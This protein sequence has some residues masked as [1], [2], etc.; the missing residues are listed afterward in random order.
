MCVTIHL[1]AKQN[2][3]NPTTNQVANDEVKLTI[4]NINNC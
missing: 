3:S 4:V 1:I 2:N